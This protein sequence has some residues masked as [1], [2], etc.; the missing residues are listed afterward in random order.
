MASK[1][2]SRGG[3][4]PRESGG[5]EFEDFDVGAGGEAEGGEFEPYDVSQETE[6]GAES[7]LA[8]LADLGGESDLAA[9]V[10]ARDEIE[11]RM[12]VE[13]GEAAFAAAADGPSGLENVVGV[14]VGEKTVDGVPTGEVAVK[15]FVKEKLNR[16]DVAAE[17]LVPQTV[18]GVTTDVDATG[19]VNAQFFGARYRPAP[20][21]VSIGRCDKVLA[22]TLG[23]L[24]RRGLQLFVL[25]NNHVMASVNTG[26]IGLGI[27]QPGRLDGGVCPNDI[28]ARLTQWVPIAFGGAPNLVD[29]AIAR[30][31]PLLVDRRILRPGG[32]RQPLLPP[33]VGPSLGMLVQKSG[34]TTQYRRGMVDAVMVTINVSYPGFG[35]ARFVGQFR[36]KGLFGA[37][38]SNAGD[39]GS[40]ITTFPANRPV[41]LLFAGNAATN[42]TFGNPIGNVLAALG[43]AIVY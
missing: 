16:E 27:P 5:A 4:A 28:I 37:V 38:F 36:V 39:S 43:V 22:G 19:E 29:A 10:Q 24:V 32:V 42:F 17:A 30:T 25:S 40:L 1:R 6:E 21:G 20:G 33:H 15:V 34:R 41:G 31:S 14:G 13:P 7:A 26:P 8:A 12:L 2:R 9:V 23:C 3:G 18:G 11:R 35:V